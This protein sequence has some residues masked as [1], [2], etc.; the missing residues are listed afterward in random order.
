MS[1][2]GE[3]IEEEEPKKPKKKEPDEFDKY[4]REVYGI[5]TE[6]AEVVRKAVPIDQVKI[7]GEEFL[8]FG[9]GDTGKGWIEEWLPE[10]SP[11]AQ[12]KFLLYAH[13]CNEYMQEEYDID[14]PED[15]E[16]EQVREFLDSPQITK[17]TVS[18]QNRARKAVN[19]LM[20]YLK[21]R[22]VYVGKREEEEAEKNGKPPVWKDP[23]GHALGRYD[24]EEK[25]EDEFDKYLKDAYGTD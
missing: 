12:A 19:S 4:L 21:K 6:E 9:R 20:K 17:L 1:K 7:G 11:K 18:E 13:L 3:E 24:K 23:L 10:L 25:D 16:R 15:W 22:D 8:V 5:E 2:K 14:K